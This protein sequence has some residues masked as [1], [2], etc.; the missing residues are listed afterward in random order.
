MK[1]ITIWN[2]AAQR[3]GDMIDG[4][5]ASNYN[6]IQSNLCLAPSPSSSTSSPA[7]I[8]P[9]SS[10]SSSGSS[11][12]SM[13]PN[14]H[15]LSPNDGHINPTN[16]TT[17]SIEGFNSLNINV[18][19]IQADLSNVTVT[20]DLTSGFS[21]GRD[22]TLVT[23]TIKQTSKYNHFHQGTELNKAIYDTGYSPAAHHV[24]DEVHELQQQLH[25]HDSS[26]VIENKIRSAA[27]I[28]SGVMGTGIPS[29]SYTIATT[30]Q[31]TSLNCGDTSAKTTTR[32]TAQNVPTNG[33]S[34]MKHS[35]SIRQVA[36]RETATKSVI[37]PAQSIELDIAGNNIEAPRVVSFMSSETTNTT[38][39][40]T[41]S[42]RGFGSSVVTDGPLGTTTNRISDEIGNGQFDRG[43]KDDFDAEESERALAEFL[44]D[45][46]TISKHQQPM[47]TPHSIL[48]A[49][50]AEMF[51]HSDRPLQAI[52]FATEPATSGADYLATHQTDFMINSNAR[53]GL[54]Y[55]P[56]GHLNHHSTHHNS[57]DNHHIQQQQQLYQPIQYHASSSTSP[58]GVL[59]DGANQMALDLAIND[60]SAFTSTTTTTSTNNNTNH[61]HTCEVC[62]KS[63]FSTKGNLKRHLRAHSGEKPF[64]CEHCD[65]CFT[66]KKSLKIHVRRHTGE[67]PYKC[68]VC[69]KL[70]SQTGVLQSHMALHKNERKF[71]CNKCGKAFRQ[72]SQ[73]KLHLMRHDGVK[74]LECSTC[75]ARFL[76]KGDLERHCRIHTG[77]RP[78]ACKM[79]DKTFTRQQ[80][81]NE[82]MNRHTGKRP[83]DCKYCDKTFSEMSACYKHAKTHKKQESIQ[84]QH[85]H[86]QQQQ[87]R[88][89]PLPPPQP[90]HDRLL[91][92]QC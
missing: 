70:F 5:M 48:A 56:S 85:H 51:T 46:E 10:S 53:L 11:S 73:L 28:E 65:S 86:V 19:A 64:K 27:S 52:Q 68:D 31:S 18:N 45:S 66:E 13:G 14:V 49:S 4:G 39:T 36:N 89:A 91:I 6:N 55:A 2:R 26:T 44:P 15:V 90:E 88:P 84:H 47:H 29:T 40:T 38:T 83:Y 71:E 58:E 60:T 87:Q 92:N 81:L 12:T 37:V 20:T 21:P 42:A 32:Q 43:P 69:G 59:S 23:P 76:T 77:E 9:S 3:L 82:H 72:R 63:G 78:Y 33:Y 16:F 79:C 30:H 35:A 8:T 62:G 22:T 34:M 54:K 25:H 74:R 7:S 24:I 17:N 61:Q 80:S 1:A 67:K 50:R 41:A 75:R 57:K